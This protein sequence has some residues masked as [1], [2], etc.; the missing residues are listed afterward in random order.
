[1]ELW[2]L[3]GEQKVA[4]D[5]LEKPNKDYQVLGGGCSNLENR[6]I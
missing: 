5:V 4:S 1:M 3:K 6:T 2:D